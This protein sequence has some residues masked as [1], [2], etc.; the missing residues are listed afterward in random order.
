M[1]R[2][3]LCLSSTFIILLL[4]GDRSNSLVLTGAYCGAMSSSGLREIDNVDDN[5]SYRRSAQG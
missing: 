5:E 3:F 2:S 4:I 1:T